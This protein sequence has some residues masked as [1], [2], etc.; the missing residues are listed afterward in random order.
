[1]INKIATSL[2]LIRKSILALA[3][4]SACSF[5]APLYAGASIA[6]A[7]TPFQSSACSG[8]K[9]VSGSGC[10]DAGASLSTTINTVVNLL[11]IVVGVAAVIMV[12]MSGLKYIT[13]AGDAQKVASAKS[14]LI[15]A[16]VGLVIVAL[17]KVIVHFVLAKA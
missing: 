17:A 11:V 14:T 12:I 2:G 5:S 7:A 8:L 6:S 9:E 15:Y 13:S 4:L 1:M 16:V 10:K 3:V